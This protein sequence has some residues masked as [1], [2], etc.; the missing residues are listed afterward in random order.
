MH[1]PLPLVQ[2][3]HTQLARGARNQQN[4]EVN[5]HALSSLYS[6]YTSSTSPLVLTHVV[7]TSVVV[8]NNSLRSLLTTTPS[9]V[10]VLLL[11]N[12]HP[13][14]LLW[15]GGIYCCW[16]DTLIQLYYYQS[17]QHYDARSL[18]RLYLFVS[19]P[20]EHRMF[21]NAYSL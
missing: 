15:D 14:L 21:C 1:L 11:S 2:I 10:V 7:V 13:A 16:D 18:K 9:V 6:R 3:K 5:E 8:V 4:L 12:Y 19:P 20:G 17:T